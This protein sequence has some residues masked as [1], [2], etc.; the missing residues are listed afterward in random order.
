V[1]AIASIKDRNA[2]MSLRISRI[3]SRLNS[4]S[5]L[6]YSQCPRSCADGSWLGRDLA[7]QIPIMPLTDQAK[8]PY[9]WAAAI[10]VFFYPIPSN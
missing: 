8:D 1:K 7:E 3:M 4:P 5:S 2:N 6:Q 10:L 9:A